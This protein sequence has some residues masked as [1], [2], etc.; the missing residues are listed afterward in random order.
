ME[1]V[2]IL[3]TIKD[4]LMNE[5]L[6][7]LAD[8]RIKLEED[9]RKENYITSPSDKKKITAIKKILSKNDEIR[10]LLSAFTRYGNGVA[11]TD[12][13]QLYVLNDEYLP[14]KVACS[15]DEDKEYAKQHNLETVPGVY[16][17]LKAIIPEEYETT[18]EI[19]TNEFILWS[20]TALKED[21]KLLYKFK[22]EDTDYCFDGQY[23]LNAIN[24]L[25]IKDPKITLE[26]R[27]NIRPITLHNKENELGL[28]LPIRTY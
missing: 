5:D 12:S 25:K 17:N 14:F 19:D 8:L 2:E 7:K 18:Y 16:P 22:V 15:T 23:L 3:K 10:P 6:L 24:I 27:G 9:V 20:K 26:L 13:Y 1:K 28:I 11:F 21:N 4:V